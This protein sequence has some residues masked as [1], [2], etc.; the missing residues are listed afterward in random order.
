M[1][2]EKPVANIDDKPINV[3]KRTFRNQLIQAY[4][5]FLILNYI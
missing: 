3:K 4:L 5:Y 1:I 2:I